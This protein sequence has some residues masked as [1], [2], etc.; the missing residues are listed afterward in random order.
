MWYVIEFSCHGIIR[1]TLPPL[2][3]VGAIYFCIGVTSLRH[4]FR[5]N[6]MEYCTIIETSVGKVNEILD[7]LRCCVREEFD[8]DRTL[9]CIYNCLLTGWDG[10]VCGRGYGCCLW[11]I[12]VAQWMWNIIVVDFVYKYS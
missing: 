5:N 10:Q 7:V 9:L 2:A 4:K 12:R 6:P 8:L 3:S 1:T 11:H